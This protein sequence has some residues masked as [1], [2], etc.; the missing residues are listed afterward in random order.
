MKTNINQS[1]DG[2]TEPW[3]FPGWGKAVR[4]SDL[5]TSPSK[6]SH[7]DQPSKHLLGAWKS[8]AICGNDITSGVFYVSAL[9]ASQAG[10]Y[11]PLALLIVS[12]VLYLFRKV[13]AEAGSALP[14]NGGTYTVLLNTTNKKLAAG[15]AYA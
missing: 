3:E 5:E 1:L 2:S 7:L 13:Y 9:C 12:L 10:F 8:T 4:I 6:I 15:A 11:P 14:L